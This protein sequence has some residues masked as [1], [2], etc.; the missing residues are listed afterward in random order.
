VSVGVFAA[1]GGV[2]TIAVQLA[3]RFGSGRVI[4]LASSPEKRELATRLG[5]DATVDSNADNLKEA[6]IEANE[7]RHL[8]VIL[9]MVGGE[10]FERSLSAVAH[11][12]RLVHFGQSARQGAPK[13]SPGKLMAT[14]RGVIGFWLM[15]LISEP[16][17]LGEALD[18]M[19]AAISAGELEVIVGDT[20]PLEEARRAHEDIR[21]RRTTGKL[22][23]V[24]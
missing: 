15:H 6:L 24:P 1:A 8:D 11:F 16:D 4:G 9:E 22:V 2:G 12:G 23:L 10:T 13:V 21:T 7:G 5:A 19:F 14:S 17:R 20:Y 18:D 3:K